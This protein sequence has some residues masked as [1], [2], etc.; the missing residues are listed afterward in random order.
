VPSGAK[1][2]ISARRADERFGGY[3]SLLN[4]KSGRWDSPVPSGANPRI[5]ARRADEGLGDKAG[6]LN[7]KS[8]RWDSPVPSGETH[9][10]LPVGQMK[11][12]GGTLA[13]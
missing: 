12:F 9:E 10:F 13:Y 2:R 8:G 1:P 5:S 3:A 7:R 6:I 11:D 4:T